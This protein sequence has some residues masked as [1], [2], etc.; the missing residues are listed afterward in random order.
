MDHETIIK[1][2]QEGRLKNAVNDFALGLDG[3]FRKVIWKNTSTRCSQHETHGLSKCVK[4][5]CLVF[6]VVFDTFRQTVELSP[7]LKELKH[8]N[9]ARW[10]KVPL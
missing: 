8:I 3:G 7:F 5:L 2:C 9:F 4:R 6:H 1:L 10:S